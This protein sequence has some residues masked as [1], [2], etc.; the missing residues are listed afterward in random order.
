MWHGAASFD[1]KQQIRK[2]VRAEP[3]KHLLKAG[4]QTVNIMAWIATELWSQLKQWNTNKH[5]SAERCLHERKSKSGKEAFPFDLF[6]VSL[7]SST[8]KQIPSLSSSVGDMF[9]YSFF[10]AELNGRWFT[11]CTP[12]P[13]PQGTN[14]WALFMANQL[15]LCVFSPYSNPCPLSLCYLKSKKMEESHW[16]Q[17]HYSKDLLRNVK[18]S[19]A[20]EILHNLLNWLE[21]RGDFSP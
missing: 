4:L 3:L 7:E 18:G 8:K 9:S 10:F 12:V 6:A 11:S 19:C 17:V 21:K 2:Y 14:L 1:L 13:C 16:K 20:P 15:F 5:S